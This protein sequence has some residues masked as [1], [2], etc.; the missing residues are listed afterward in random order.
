MDETIS[1]FEVEAI[2]QQRFSIPKTNL[3]QVRKTRP[4][5]KL[6]KQ[7]IILVVGFTMGAFMAYLLLK[8]LQSERRR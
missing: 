5:E 1:P 3:S 2:N 4:F 6:E 7:G 8:L